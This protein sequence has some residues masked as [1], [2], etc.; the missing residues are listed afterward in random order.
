MKNL[1]YLLLFCSC[2][3]TAQEQKYVLPLI[4]K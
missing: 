1:F 2:A 3:I 4:I